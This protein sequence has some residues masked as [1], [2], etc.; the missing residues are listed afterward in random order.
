MPLARV[1]PCYVYPRLFRL[2]G[3]SVAELASSSMTRTNA[4][5]FVMRAADVLGR[6]RA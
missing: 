2:A 1:F 6:D 5:L 3:I 4:F